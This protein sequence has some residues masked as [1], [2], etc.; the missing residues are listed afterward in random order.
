MI[1][2]PAGEFIMG[3]DADDIARLDIKQDVVEDE[4]PRHRVY[5]DTFYIDKYEVTNAHFQQFVQVT[6]HRTQAEREDW[7]RVDTGDECGTV[8]GANW[9]APRGPGSSIAESRAAPGDTG[10]PR[11]RQSLL[12]LG[13]ETSSY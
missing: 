1:L 6:G 7:G 13:R 3:S 9:R 11:R 4:I 2:V 5:L 12:R 10:K 8:N